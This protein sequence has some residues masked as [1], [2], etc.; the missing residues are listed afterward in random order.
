MLLFWLGG[1]RRG[2]QREMMRLCDRYVLIDRYFQ[3]HETIESDCH[4]QKT[5]NVINV[6]GMLL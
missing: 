5:V 4:T 2:I 6:S 3:I 1:G